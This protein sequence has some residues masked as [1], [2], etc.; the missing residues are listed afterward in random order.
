ME[1][2][3]AYA[4]ESMKAWSATTAKLLP[5]MP[6]LPGLH[7]IGD[8]PMSMVS[9]SYDFAERLLASQ[10]SFVEEMVDLMTPTPA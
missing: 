5:A 2:S 6:A 3:K 10:R 9:M 1:T 4:L 8:G 7:T